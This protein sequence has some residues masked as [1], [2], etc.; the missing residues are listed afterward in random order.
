MNKEEALG[1]LKKLLVSDNLVYSRM[2]VP[3]CVTLESIAEMSRLSLEPTDVWVVTYPKSG[4]TWI[5]NIVKLLRNNGEKDGIVLDQSIPWIEANSIENSYCNQ[6]NLAASPRPRAFKCHLPYDTIPSG[7]P[8]T[9]PCKYIY[10]V[11][12]PK[13]VVVSFYFHY[14]RFSVEKDV[15]LEWEL[16]FRNFV[17]GNLQFGDFFDHV[18]SWWSHRNEDNV[19]FLTYEGLKKDPR[20]VIA[21]IAKFIE[22]NVSDGVIDKV[23]ADTSFNSMSKDD[24]ANK[25]QLIANPNATPF[26]RKGEVGD[27]RNYLTAEQSAEI[28]QLCQEK[29][30]GTGLMFDFGV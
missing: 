21:R 11:R 27:W 23:V 19:L 26:M 18:L 2:N 16:F 15:T 30:R 6:I 20:T 9:T 4:T 28:D 22:A 3:S 17:Y 29:L 13:D 10:I 24:T 14:I 12:N 1:A 25:S 7:K 5:Q 8:H